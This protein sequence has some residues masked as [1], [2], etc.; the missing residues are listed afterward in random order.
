MKALI[1]GASSGIGREFA[2]Q[3]ANEGY[4]MII[5]GRRQERLEEIKK[6]IKNVNVDVYACDLSKEEDCYKLF[7]EFPDIDLLVNNA[8][9]G[10]FGDFSK[11][12]LDA[13]IE[14]INLNIKALHILM[15][16]YLQRMEEKNSGNIINVASSAAFFPG[17]MFSSYYSSKAYVYRMTL[18][19]YEELRRKN[20]KVRVSVLC[21]GPV[22]TEFNS[23]AGVKFGLSS[24][25]VDYV[26]RYTLKMLKK[27]KTVITPSLSI[28]LTRILSKIV[29]DKI[30]S[31]V[32]YKIQ[33]AKNELKTS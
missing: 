5:T 11:T 9:F 19:I 23:V 28:K 32:V 29:P 6:N 10:V 18:A 30:A 33:K 22:D 1:T 7:K 27:K 4:D 3:L 20:S 25:T 16:L 14:M 24:V 15:K 26:V 12:D 21:P 13:E 31:R 8:G 2:Y 17:P